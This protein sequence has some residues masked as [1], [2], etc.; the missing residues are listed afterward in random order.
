MTSGIVEMTLFE[1]MLSPSSL[2]SKNNRGTCQKW[3][4]KWNC[5]HSRVGSMS[6]LNMALFC[7]VSG[8]VHLILFFTGLRGFGLSYSTS[9]LPISIITIPSAHLMSNTAKPATVPPICSRDVDLCNN[10]TSSAISHKSFFLCLV[11]VM[12]ESLWPTFDQGHFLSTSAHYPG[13]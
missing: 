9:H 2:S 7:F 6:L 8:W 12:W 5:N 4:G 10:T 11:S 13:R 3:W 1:H